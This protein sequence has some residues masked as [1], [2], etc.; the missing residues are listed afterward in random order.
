VLPPELGE[1][2]DDEQTPAQFEPE[3]IKQIGVRFSRHLPGV[4]H[5][6]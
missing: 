3:I 4:K 2:R 5:Y 1:D 6:V